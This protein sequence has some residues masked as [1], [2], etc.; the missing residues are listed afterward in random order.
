MRSSKK[1][2]KMLT[3]GARLLEVRRHIYAVLLL[4]TVAP[5]KIRIKTFQYIKSRKNLSNVRRLI[6]RDTRRD[7]DRWNFSYANARYSELKWP[8]RVIRALYGDAMLVP[9]WRA[10]T[11]PPVTNK[12]IRHFTEFCCESVNSTA[13]E[14]ITI[15]MKLFLIQELFR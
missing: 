15:K 1:K 2:E 13:E 9:L 3:M 10:P 4:F 11:W 8:I 7:S 14:L 6:C 12:N 5:C